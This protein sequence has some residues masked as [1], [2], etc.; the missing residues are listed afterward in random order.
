MTCLQSSKVSFL[1]SRNQYGFHHSICA[2]RIVFLQKFFAFLRILIREINKY[3]QGSKLFCYYNYFIHRIR[4][5]FISFVCLTKRWTNVL[6]C[7]KYTCLRTFTPKSTGL[8][9]LFPIKD[10]LIPP[11]LAV[12]ILCS[13][14]PFLSWTV[15]L[16]V[17]LYLV[18]CFVSLPGASQTYYS[19]LINAICCSVLYDERYR[20]CQH[21]C[22]QFWLPNT[23][24]FLRNVA[25]DFR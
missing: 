23:S 3:W 6:C 5:M 15:L 12:C 2:G 21:I 16:L 8:F 14:F 22:H 11:F 4:P 10:K 1:S 18:C 20:S 19:M 7:K 13:T 24:P 25:L 17:T 9:C